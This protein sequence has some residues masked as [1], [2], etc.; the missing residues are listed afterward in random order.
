MQHNGC[1]PLGG[2]DR[3]CWRPMTRSCRL[4]G[5]GWWHLGKYENS[6]GVGT[7]CLGSKSQGSLAVGYLVQRGEDC[8]IHCPD[9]V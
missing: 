2:P 5:I 7:G 8:G 1:K 3:Q 6:Q 9:I 4:H